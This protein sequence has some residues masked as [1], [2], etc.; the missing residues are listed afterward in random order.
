MLDQWEEFTGGPA[1][2]NPDAFHVTLNRRGHIFLNQRSC[3]ALGTPQGVRLFFNKI[4][5]KI[6]IRPAEMLTA[7][8]FPMNKKPSGSPGRVIYASSFCTHHGI[9]LHATVVFPSAELTPDGMLILDLND[10]RTIRRD[11]G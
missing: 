11:K 1:R 5:S 10:T 3:E 6:G 2:R 4:R 8:V 7:K 9:K